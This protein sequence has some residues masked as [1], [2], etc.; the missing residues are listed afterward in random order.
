MHRKFEIRFLEAGTYWGS[1]IRCWQMRSLHQAYTLWFLHKITGLLIL[2]AATSRLEGAWSFE[3]F[4]WRSGWNYFL[5]LVES[6]RALCHFIQSFFLN[7]IVTA[8]HAAMP[9]QCVILLQSTIQSFIMQKYILCDDL[10]V[11]IFT[12][13]QRVTR[14][15]F[16]VVF[17]LRNSNWSN[18]SRRETFLKIGRI[19]TTFIIWVFVSRKGHLIKIVL[20]RR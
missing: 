17:L 4:F 3:H 9:F 20:S 14:K 10:R 13:L 16:R 12:W 5:A 19:F 7:L 1:L 11:E 6:V 18:S 8:T 15:M 2:V